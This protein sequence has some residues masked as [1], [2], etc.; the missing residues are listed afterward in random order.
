[1]EIN[2][3]MDI[4]LKIISIQLTLERVLGKGDSE[5]CF[6]YSMIFIEIVGN[7]G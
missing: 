1:M 5:M 2:S 4:K 7:V 3:V 6:K